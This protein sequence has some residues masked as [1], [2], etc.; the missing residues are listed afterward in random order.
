M[1]ATPLSDGTV[2]AHDAELSHRM[3]PGV[4]PMSWRG[5]VDEFHAAFRP[6]DPD[7][8][9]FPKLASIQ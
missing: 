1:R 6:I 8:G 7:S 3:I 2:I 9:N 4:N 5:T